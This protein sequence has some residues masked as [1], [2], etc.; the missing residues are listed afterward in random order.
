[1]SD[2]FYVGRDLTGFEDN[3][4]TRP[5]SRV[6]LA[7]DDDNVITAG[8]DSGYEITATCPHATQEMAEAIL[9]KLKGYRYQMYTAE[10]ANIDPA[11]ELGDAVTADGV[12]GVI[13][14]LSD[15]GGGYPDI[16]APGETELEDEY[17]IE[18]P[19][20]RRF[21]KSLAKTNSRISKQSDEINLKI[22][23]LGKQ[24]SEAL[25]QKYSE[26]DQK[27]DSIKLSVVNGEGQSTLSLKAGET[28]LSSATIVFS[29]F[30]TFTDLSTSGKT[31]ISGGKLTTD[32]IQ[33][34]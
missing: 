10:A 29:G 14:R 5:V 21:K 15:D 19:M 6:T 18:G 25:E 22:E 2:K 26:I 12:Y 16:T 11:A 27:I 31:T 28:E 13:S 33:D 4:K 7:I 34:Q 3:G 17:P 1:M 9:A 20:T 30:V 23:E 8:D 32:I 24:S